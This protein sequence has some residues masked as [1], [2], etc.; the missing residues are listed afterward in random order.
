MQ[1]PPEEEIA[2]ALRNGGDGSPEAET[3]EGRLSD[4]GLLVQAGAE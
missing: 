4:G 1:Y 2:E 3:I